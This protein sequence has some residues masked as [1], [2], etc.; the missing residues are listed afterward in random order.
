MTATPPSPPPAQTT[1]VASLDDLEKQ[2]NRPF[3]SLFRWCKELK[4]VVN[5]RS[6]AWEDVPILETRHAEAP[7]RNFKNGYYEQRRGKEE[8]ARAKQYREQPPP[9]EVSPATV[10]ITLPQE[11]VRV[12][13]RQG[14]P[15]DVWAL[16]CVHGT[17][18]EMR[19]ELTKAKALAT[20]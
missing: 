13:R 19:R 8:R 5:Q 9:V 18:E 7:R 17:M 16:G 14:I 3:P 11:G 15:L 10:T 12:A 6:I 2:W 1:M 4:I 20:S